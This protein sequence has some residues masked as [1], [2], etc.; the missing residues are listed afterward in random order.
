M[1]PQVAETTW[2][3]CRLYA[4]IS[5]VFPRFVENPPN[6]SAG[7][8]IRSPELTTRLEMHFR[9]FTIGCGS[10]SFA[11]RAPRAV[12]SWQRCSHWIAEGGCG[13][14]GTVHRVDWL[15]ETDLREIL[16]PNQ[17]RVVCKPYGY[18]LTSICDE[19]EHRPR[20]MFSSTRRA[21]ELNS[22]SLFQVSHEILRPS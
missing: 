12:F 11:E 5:A 13:T 20:K 22:Q 7:L 15:L 6:A 10:D 16:S 3:V 19:T 14:P 21:C 4:T 17:L 2:G 18:M 1:R 9:M 8:G